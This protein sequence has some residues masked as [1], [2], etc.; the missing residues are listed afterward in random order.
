MF[1][2]LIDLVK[3]V[4]EIAQKDRTTN[5]LYKE[6]I[7]EIL[8]EISD[9]LV[10]TAEKLKRDEYPHMN[11]AILER[12]SSS[13]KFH[14]MDFIAPHQLEKLEICLT[15]ASQVEKQFALRSEVD[16]IPAIEYA[17]GEFKAMAIIIKL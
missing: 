9:V 7:S 8:N 4:V 11:C 10:D 1:S 5:I 6:K 14:A 15:E 13:L 12:L 16:T 17:A 2:L 3:N